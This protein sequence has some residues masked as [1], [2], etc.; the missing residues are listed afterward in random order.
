MYIIYR[1]IDGS[2]G[3]INRCLVSKSLLMPL[4]FVLFGKLISR[5]RRGVYHALRVNNPLH[6]PMKINSLK[7]KYHLQMMALRVHMYK[8]EGKCDV[9]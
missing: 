6:D 4:L 8:G 7:G 5:K 2:Y 1:A 3:A 9:A